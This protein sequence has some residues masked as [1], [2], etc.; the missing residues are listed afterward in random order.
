MPACS[1]LWWFCWEDSLETINP[2]M[3]DA[4]WRRFPGGWADWRSGRRN[5]L[6]RVRSGHLG[7]TPST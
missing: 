2:E 1:G 7:L 5:A 6:F 3:Q 4:N